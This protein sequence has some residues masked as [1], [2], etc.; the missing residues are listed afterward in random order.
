LDKGGTVKTF[1]V[2]IASARLMASPMGLSER[3]EPAVVLR[4]VHDMAAG[5]TGNLIGKAS[6]AILFIEFANSLGETD[7][8]DDRW[9]FRDR[10]V[11]LTDG[12]YGDRPFADIQ[13]L[14][15]RSRLFEEG[16]RAVAADLDAHLSRLVL[17]ELEA[18][19]EYHPPANPSSLFLA[20]PVVAVRSVGIPAGFIAFLVGAGIFFL[21]VS[22][23]RVP[24]RLLRWPTLDEFVGMVQARNAWVERVLSDTLL[25]EFDV[26]EGDR[27]EIMSKGANV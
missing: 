2:S 27:F 18:C 3:A 6:G 10:E 16:A 11:P 4:A 1:M 15:A 21:P 25:R 19:K 9:F 24:C 12:L 5:F 22:I 13:L 26:Q 20:D 17:S 23:L 8:T 14:P 7:L